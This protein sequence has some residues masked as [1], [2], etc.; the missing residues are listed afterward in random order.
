MASSQ[1]MIA[2][3][4]WKVIETRLDVL[5]HIRKKLAWCQILDSTQNVLL[6][7][8]W[9]HLVFQ[10]CKNFYIW[11]REHFWRPCKWQLHLAFSLLGGFQSSFCF[12]DPRH[13][14]ILEFALIKCCRIVR[15]SWRLFLILISLRLELGMNELLDLY[16]LWMKNT[17]FV[18]S[19]CDIGQAIAGKLPSQ[20][21]MAWA[22]NMLKIALSHNLKVVPLWLRFPHQ[23]L[24]W[25][26]SPRI[27]IMS[28]SRGLRRSSI[29]LGAP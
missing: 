8:K 1:A 26:S 16:Y 14:L 21:E 25:T 7:C 27:W 17:K 2:K 20:S 11:S 23:I 24:D 13:C 22:K 29:N 4:K 12:P 10:Q 6:S 5:I 28:S 9:S 15:E 18:L 19:V 3:G